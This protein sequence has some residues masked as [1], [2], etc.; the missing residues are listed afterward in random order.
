MARQIRVLWLTDESPDRGLG[1]GS[2]RQAYLFEALAAEYPTDLVVVGG[3][4]DERVRDAAESL[5]EVP[6]RSGLWTDH[7]VGR[8]LLE[9]GIMAGSRLPSYAYPARPARRALARAVEDHKGGYDLVCVEHAALAPLDV[10][11]IA[12]KRVITF[13]HLFSGMA[14]QELAIAPGPRQR[15]YR[16]L[17]LRKAERLERRAL[18]DFDHVIVCSPEDAAA[19]GGSAAPLDRDRISVIANGVDLDAFRPAPLPAERRVLFPA[20]LGYAPNVDGALWFCTEIWPLVRAAVPGATVELVGREPVP[21]VLALQELDGISV[22]ADVPSMTPHYDGA[23]VV[24]VPLRSGTGTRLKALEAMASGRP[25]VGTTIGLEGIGV[26]DREQVLIAEEPGQF[27]AAVT[28]LLSDDVLADQIAAAGRV[29][30]EQR[31]GWDRI[32]RDYV[33]LIGR[34]I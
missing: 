3:T 19:F 15:A 2:I 28:D 13:H 33:D 1:G 17:D 24:V 32:G 22:H 10:S 12:R 16:S 27:A 30:V 25:V 5:K 11:A 23:S 20:T 8:R 21:E 26:R 7:P 6:K 14:R 9:L 4:E 18:Q 31:F 29:H 34:L